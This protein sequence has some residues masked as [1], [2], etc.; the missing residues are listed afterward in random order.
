METRNDD[1]FAVI[2]NAQDVLKS[3]LKQIE[4]EINDSNSNQTAGFG[5]RTIDERIVNNYYM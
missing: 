4:N 1:S 2:E 3:K 5:H